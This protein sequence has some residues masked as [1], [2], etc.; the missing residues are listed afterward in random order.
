VSEAPAPVARGRR[1]PSA[2]ET[3]YYG[4]DVVV[5]APETIDELRSLVRDAEAE[6]R[7]VIPAGLGAHA[8]VADP[9]APGALVVST[10]RFDG[11]VEYEPDD[12]TIGVGAGMPLATL[13]A[14]LDEQ[15]QELPVDLGRAAGGTVGGLVARAPFGPRSAHHGRIATLLLGVEGL[16]GGGHS[17]KSG[18]MVVKNVAGYQIG[19]FLVGAHGSGG[20]LLRLN[21][22]LRSKPPKHSLRLARFDSSTEAL[23]FA[24]ALRRDRLEPAMLVLLS[25]AAVDDIRELGFEGRPGDW[26]VAWMFEG[27]EPRVKWLANESE[28]MARGA[29]AKLSEAYGEEPAAKMLDY[30][31]GFAEAAEPR[32]NLGIARVVVLPTQLAELE[33]R[34]RTAFWDRVGILAGFQM[35]VASGVLTLRWTAEPS[36][37][38]EPLDDVRKAALAHD[39]QAT[40]LHLPPTHRR[41][42]NRLLTPDPNAALARK[43]LDVFDPV[44]IFGVRE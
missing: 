17:F 7:P 28:R 24:A 18:G 9:P 23:E 42:R 14:T 25:D 27:I 21:F 10:H 2:L 33:L 39:G 36:R 34:L 20:F 38:A 30:L 5:H 41:G 43:I 29:P 4:H 22:K 1:A 11:V 26:I 31:A 12:F 32:E 37:V 3:A 44:N 8:G 13:R 16:R 19:K 15:G 40:L 35:D 6:R